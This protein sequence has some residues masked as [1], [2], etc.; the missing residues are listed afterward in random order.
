MQPYVRRS[1]RVPVQQPVVVVHAG[2]RF[3]VVAANLSLGGVF[4]EP[5]L[6]LEYGDRLE[7]QLHAPETRGVVRLPGIVRWSSPNG[8]GVQFQQLGA[9]ETHALSVLLTAFRAAQARAAQVQ[10]TAISR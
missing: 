7:V 2:S 10:A 6:G 1:L 3:E 9:R 4:I 8:F 5:H